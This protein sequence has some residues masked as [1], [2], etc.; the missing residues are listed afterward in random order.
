[1]SYYA[2]LRQLQPAE[3]T[4]LRRFKPEWPQIKLLDI[5]VGG[6]R[7]TQHFAPLVSEYVGIDYSADMIAACKRRFPSTSQMHFQV[8][9]VR[10]L[11]Q[12]ADN[13]FDFILFSFNGIDYIS[14]EERLKALQEISRVGKSGGYFFFSTHSLQGMI[15]EFKLQNKFSFNPLKTYVNLVMLAILRLANRSL[16]LAQ[17]QQLDHAIIKDESHNFRLKT[18]YINPADQLKQLAENF[19]DIQIYSWSTGLEI[20][21]QLELDANV[22]MWLYYL[23][24]IK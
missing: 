4:I 16:T 20:K 18:Y 3:A 19:Y 2:Q 22:E 23:C 1:M 7:T 8:C 17:L 13:T 6:G 15:R 14:H 24:T 5:G 21:N 12:F 10:D 11:S 9:D